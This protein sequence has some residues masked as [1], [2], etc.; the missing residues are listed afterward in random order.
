MAMARIILLVGF[1]TLKE[2]SLK[3]S[4][5]GSEIGGSV[6]EDAEEEV[7]WIGW[8]Y[9]LKSTA[10][11]P[12]GSWWRM[13]TVA[14][15]VGRVVGKELAQKVAPRGGSCGPVMLGNQGPD[16]SCPSGP[17]VCVPDGEGCLQDTE[18]VLTRFVIKIS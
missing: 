2:I 4:L 5:R 6:G 17:G 8:S 14:L 16:H 1:L 10:G 15:T 13:L 9:R 18:T 11:G 12:M 7:L 3:T